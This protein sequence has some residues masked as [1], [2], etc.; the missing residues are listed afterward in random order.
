MVQMDNQ[1][2]GPKDRVVAYCC[3]FRLG[4]AVAL[5]LEALLIFN[6]LEPHAISSRCHKTDKLLWVSMYLK[7]AVVGQSNNDLKLTD[8]QE[9]MRGMHRKEAEH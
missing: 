5:R 7:T 9:E 8:K 2:G 6:T 1:K 3:F 4:I